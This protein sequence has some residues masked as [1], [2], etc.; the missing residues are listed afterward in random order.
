LKWISL[1]RRASRTAYGQ[2]RRAAHCYRDLTPVLFHQGSLFVA[3]ADCEGIFAL[4]SGSGQLLWESHLAEDAVHLLGVGGGSLLVSGD[5]LWWIDAAGG[6]VLD[7][8]PAETPHGFGRG[9]LA[10]GRVY[11]PT[12]DLLYVFNQAIVPGSHAAMV[13]DPISVGEA[14]GA[15]PGKTP[16]TIVAFGGNLVP[17]DGVLLVAT[18]D[19]IYGFRQPGGPKPSNSPPAT[20]AAPDH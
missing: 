3:P 17:A 5:R 8:W 1:Y 19:R 15:L 9:V 7:R 4:D 16:H 6:K 2:D 14:Q 12:R 11:W 18:S 10:D 20:P 13:R